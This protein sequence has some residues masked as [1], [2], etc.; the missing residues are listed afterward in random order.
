MAGHRGALSQGWVP[1]LVHYVKPCVRPKGQD[2]P[3]KSLVYRC[4]I[5]SGAGNM[6]ADR[7]GRDR[8]SIKFDNS[9]VDDSSTRRPAGVIGR[10]GHHLLS[11]G[12][13]IPP[14]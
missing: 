1:S 13:T 5:G 8:R 11:R 2:G 3:G 6:L 4:K 10:P 9:L 7:P 12:S 14:C